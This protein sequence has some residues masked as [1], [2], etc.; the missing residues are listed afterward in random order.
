MSRRYGAATARIF[1]GSRRKNVAPRRILVH[2]Q[3]VFFTIWAS[4][5]KRPGPQESHLR[6]SRELKWIPVAPQ[7]FSR[8]AQVVKNVACA[9]TTVC[10]STSSGSFTWA[11]PPDFFTGV[12]PPDFFKSFT[13]SSSNGVWPPDFFKSFTEPSSTG[14]WPPDFFKNFVGIGTW[15]WQLHWGLAASEAGKN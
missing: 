8:N 9:C 11:L 7:R 4:R 14:V 6:E 3:P 13:E 10:I 5:E 2:A 1:G 12:W 15:Q